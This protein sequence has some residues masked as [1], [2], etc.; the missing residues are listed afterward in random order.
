MDTLG[1]RLSEK[2]ATFESHIFD[3]LNHD[4]R[5]AFSAYVKELSTRIDGIDIVVAVAGTAGHMAE[6]Y[7]DDQWGLDVCK[8]ITET[9][10][11]GTLTLVMAVW[12]DM[13][14]RK[15]G[16][17]CIVGSSAGVFAPATFCAY[18]A[19]K[20]YWSHFAQSLR[21]VS[22]PYNVKVNI[23]LPGFIDTRMTVNMRSWNSIMPD[24]M[25][26]PASGM[27]A[28]IVSGIEHNECVTNWPLNQ[29]LPLYGA[30]VA[31]PLNEEIGRLV[32]AASLATGV[33]M[34]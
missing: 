6:A 19:S 27:A 4:H 25:F 28:A 2:G 8:R 24:F 23:A 16:H 10:V 1:K 18:G 31:T 15:S 13:V 26:A 30:K 11:N 33:T 3:H 29:L 17:I 7:Q 32:G 20:A 12:E 21:V 14:K 5:N 34:S 22:L 9:N